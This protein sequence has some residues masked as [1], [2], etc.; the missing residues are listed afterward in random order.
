MRKT[1]LFAVILGMAVL[2]GCSNQSEPITATVPETVEAPTEAEP[3]SEEPIEVTMDIPE[4]EEPH[5]A[6]PAP[7]PV[8][9]AVE[10]PTEEATEVVEDA[11]ETNHI[12]LK[13]GTVIE[14]GGK[15]KLEDVKDAVFVLN[16][17]EIKKGDDYLT[18]AFVSKGRYLVAEDDFVNWA[19]ENTTKGGESFPIGKNYEYLATGDYDN[20]YVAIVNSAEREK[21]YDEAFEKASAGGEFDD[22]AFDV[23]P[24]ESEKE[25]NFTVIK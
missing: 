5:E 4:P 13:D 9:E 8:T 10:E 22:E 18:V 19:Y 15:I 6:A 16:G 7:E 20:I 12:R 2:A 24:L 1:K 21:A 25:F 3:V 17:K 14:D 11:T 23:P